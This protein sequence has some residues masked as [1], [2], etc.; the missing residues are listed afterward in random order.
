MTTLT[1]LGH[2][3]LRLDAPSVSL[4][5]DPW[6]AATGAF[7]GAWHQ[8]PRNDHLDR[9]RL[10]DAD[11][12]AVS[13]EHLD[14]MDASVLA[15]LPERTRV[16]IPAY[17]SPAFRERLAAHGVR[18]IIELR[19]WEQLALDR[20]GSWL[21]VIPEQS[22]MCHD[23][24]FL[25]Q[26]GGRSVLNC[27]D[28][29][30]S[31]AQARR[32]AV[33]AGGQLDLMA[34]QTSGASWHPR[35]YAY[36][37]EVRATI[38]ASKRLSKFRAVL[39]LVRATGPRLAVPFAGPPCFLDP[40]L[41]A[42][43]ASIAAPGIFPD[44]E[45]A[46][47]WLAEHLP[48]QRFAAFRPGDVLDLDSGECRP[49]P[50]AR[51]NYADLAGYLDRYAADRA[52][53]LA[54]TYAAHPEPDPG[55]AELF[56]EHF[57]RLGG[58]NPWFL[59]RIGL[60]MRFEVTGRYGGCWDVAMNA[61]RLTVDLR[62][63]SSSPNYT[64]RVDGRWLQPVLLGQEGWESLLLS[65]R[66]AAW[67]EP[68]VYNDYLVGFLKHAN[69]PALQAVQDYETGRDAGERVVVT[70]GDGTAYEIDR[71]C[72]HAGEDLTEGAVVEGNV[73]RCLAHNFEYDLRTG[74]C[75]NARSVA[76]RSS[77]P[78]AGLSGWRGAA[79]CAPSA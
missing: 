30:L 35:C 9:P 34:V 7:F 28:A 17:P 11:W 6:F 14:H 24:A 53:A 63:R 22:P 31:A 62:G 10:L 50:S 57:G 36:P 19:A 64:L 15:N 68:D 18:R 40:A 12:V 2:A 54:A 77:R 37:D 65:L 58:L 60:T 8:F 55:L 51:L 16:V 75:R 72:P 43:N 66:V 23:S 39:R 38:E 41:R 46:A 78:A 4:V 71:Y 74:A 33:L 67:R 1:F 76:L 29:R 70:A 59:G 20:S 61:D 25:V 44:Q 52:G 42:H 13:H 32:A 47:G 73:L 21:T 3:G 69:A 79:G 27:N 49:D 26:V 56:A 45:Q 5:M 48:Q